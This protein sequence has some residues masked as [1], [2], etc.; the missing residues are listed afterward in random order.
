GSIY[1]SI[2]AFSDAGHGV[3]ASG[4]DYAPYMECCDVWENAAGE[5]DSSVGNLT[6]IF[7]NFSQDPELCGREI[8]DYR[9]FDTSPCTASNSP[10]GVRVGSADAF[11]DS[12]VE[13]TS[14]GRLKA[15]YR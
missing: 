6:G 3:G 5:Y 14:W 8:A 10:C 7:D 4:Q 1:Q 11:C 15:L 2:I 9:L 12:P 13:A